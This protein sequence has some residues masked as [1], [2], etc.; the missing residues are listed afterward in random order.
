M[1]YHKWRKRAVRLV[2]ELP[3]LNGAAVVCAL[4]EV[5]A[6]ELRRFGVTVPIAIV[7]NGTRPAPQVYHLHSGAGSR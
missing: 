6:D 2:A 1:R 5:E 4:S 7:S 3:M